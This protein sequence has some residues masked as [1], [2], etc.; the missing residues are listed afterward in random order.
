[1]R[2]PDHFFV[3]TV[4]H[5]YVLVSCD[6]K[7]AEEARGLF[8]FHPITTCKSCTLTPNGY[9]FWGQNGHCQGRIANG[10]RHLAA[11]LKVRAAMQWTARTDREYPIGSLIGYRFKAGSPLYYR[12]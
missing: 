3:I 7:R 12:G 10:R 8:G 9:E 5:V 2:R 11:C 1:M 4:H 6:E